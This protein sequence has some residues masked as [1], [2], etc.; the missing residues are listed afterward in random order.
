ML[1]LPEGPLKKCDI[2]DICAAFQAAA[3]DVLVDRTRNALDDFLT[4]Y[5]TADALVIAGGVAA[6]Q[7]LRDKLKLLANEKSISLIAPP[8]ELCTDNGAMIA[9]A[10]IERIQTMGVEKAKS[11]LNFKPRPRWSLDPEAPPVSFA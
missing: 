11:N 2:S 4:D 10:A 3:G 8:L 5:P 7:S 1:D 6:N 9:W